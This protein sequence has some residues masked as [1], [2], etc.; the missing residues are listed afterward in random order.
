MPYWLW[1]TVGFY[2]GKVLYQKKPVTVE[3]VLE[4]EPGDKANRM[5]GRLERR[6]YATEAQRV[7]ARIA[8]EARQAAG[9]VNK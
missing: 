6:K 5:M 2:L 1:M 4:G 3:S 9:A 8:R 7:A